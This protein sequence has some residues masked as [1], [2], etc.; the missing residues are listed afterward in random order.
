[1]LFI[2]KPLVLQL[3]RRL[4]WGA[5]GSTGKRVATF[6][7]DQDRTL[8]SD[9][10]ESFVLPE[11]A[12]VGVVHPLD[13]S[14]EELT[15]W[16]QLFA[17]YEIVQ[18]FPQ[19]D[20]EVFRPSK[21]EAKAASLESHHDRSF[22]APKL[23]FGLE[24]LGWKRGQASDGGSFSGHSKIFAG[25]GLVAYVEYAGAVAMGYIED[26]ET[27]TLSTVSFERREDRGSKALA[28]GDVDAIVVS[29]VIR[30]LSLLAGP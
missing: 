26:K 25:A 9:R 21:E 5:W 22:P 23:V 28:I 14:N 15:R 2:D 30:D 4:I 13:L 18:P 16:G 11:G 8:S 27:L 20:R 6:R 7:V 29:E 19:L 12:L 24:K 17:D 1:M 3:A 10:D